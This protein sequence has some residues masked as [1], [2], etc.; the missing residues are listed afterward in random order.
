MTKLEKTVEEL[1]QHADIKLG[2]TRPQD[3]T[4]NNPA[5]YGRVLRDR[6]LGLGES[7]MD[8]WWDSPQPDA[9]I[10]RI[11]SADLA[12]Q[13][14]LSPAI[15]ASGA[16]S[17]V[18]ASF[19]NRQSVKKAKKN[20]EHHY[21]IGNDLYELMLDKRMI[22]SCGYWKGAKTLDQA[23]ENKLD[24][25]C[26][27][28]QL[29]KGMTLLDIGCGWGG[30]AEFAATK[31]GVKVTGISPAIEQVKKAK[32]RTKGL[33]VTILQ[34]DYRHMT[35]SFDRIVSIGMLEHVGVKNYQTFFESC[36][37]LLKPGGMMLHHTIG[38]NQTYNP[39]EAKWIDKYI[40]PGGVIP[41]IP[42][43]VTPAQKYFVVEDIQN[44]GPDYDKTLMA[45]HKNFVKSYPKIKDSYDE[46]FYR[47]WEYYL[48]MFAAGF[49][50]RNLQLWQFVMTRHE[51]TPRY[52]APR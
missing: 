11:L 6:E 25:I 50:T 26:R 2:G 28:L 43:V 39:S 13:V 36:N 45:W 33:N 12:S 18:S 15:I 5:V 52:D 51:V 31:Y 42:E 8:G 3:V 49:R 44:F 10:T 9:F 32:E 24:L 21:N 17:V 22:Y 20:A 40:F 16:K 29:K 47:M 46:R 23:Q 37:A 19:S 7:Y 14:K 35:G 30:F 41:T 4:I 38:S 48:L 1:F 34:K 27:K